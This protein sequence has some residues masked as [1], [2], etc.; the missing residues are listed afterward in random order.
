MKV[1]LRPALS[2]DD[3]FLLNLYTST[4]AEE[5]EGFA[6]PPEQQAAF[7][8]MQFTA[9]RRSYELAYK[10]ME[11]SIILAGAQPVGRIIVFR[12]SSEIHLVDLALLPEFQGQ[13]IGS[14]LIGNLLHEA[15]AAG[16]CVGLQVEKKNTKARRLYDRLGFVVTSEDEMYCAMRWNPPP[17]EK[18][19]RE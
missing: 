19:E 8:R 11:H 1:A 18:M 17:S 13:R 7:F 15:L 5:V 16:R 10:G 3:D 2:E 4:R 12:T 9:Q 6:W 14:E